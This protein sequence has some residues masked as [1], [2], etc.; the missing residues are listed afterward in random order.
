MELEV[1]VII[2]SFGDREGWF[3]GDENVLYLHRNNGY[4]KFYTC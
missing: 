4:T 2:A 3:L 1:N